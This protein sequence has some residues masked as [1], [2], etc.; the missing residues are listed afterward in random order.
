M[1]DLIVELNNIEISIARRNRSVTPV[2]DVSFAIEGGQR[3]GVVGESGSGKT[4][5][6]S[7]ILGLLPDGGHVSGGSGR[8][9]DVDLTRATEADFRRLRGS[10]MGLIPQDPLTSLNPVYRIGTQLA[11]AAGAKSKVPRQV[12]ESRAIELL[13]MV[14]IPEASKRVRAY[15]HEFSGGMRQRVLIAMALAQ[16]PKLLIA[17]EATTALDVTVQAQVLDLID[18]L[19]REQGSAVLLIT[20]DLAVAAGRTDHLVVM[21]GGRVVEQGRTDQ[22]L[23]DPQ[24]DYTKGLLAASP[25]FDKPRK[26]EFQVFEGGAR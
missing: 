18:E 2:K 26:S 13:E 12:A 14:G 5:T 19:A 6:A 21:R 16:R 25:T 23:R 9:A 7:A 3:L 24:H 10:Y 20:H 17:D 11:E 1:S 4:M 15:P 8:V 22:V